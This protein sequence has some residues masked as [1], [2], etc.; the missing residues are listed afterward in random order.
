MNS[1][2]P[3]IGLAAISAFLH[4]APPEAPPA[5][6]PTQAPA[7]EPSSAALDRHRDGSSE[8][9]DAQDE[10]SADVQQL[11]IEQTVP[12]V[13]KLFKEVETIMDEATDHLAAND[14]GGQTLAAQTEVIEKIHAAAKERQKQSGSGQSGSAMM[15]MMERMMGKTPGEGDPQKGKGDKPS[16]Q[17]GGGVQGN[18]DSANTTTG[19]A[20]SN[21]KSEVRRVPKAA[22]TAGQEIPSEFRSAFD[23]FNRGSEVRLKSPTAKP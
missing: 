13:I 10:L 23:A 12:E 22:G 18:S 17:G 4:A 15:D 3:I 2:F 20:D 21:G 7:A 5:T 1:L 9:A 11:T 8:V 6:P 16:D 14:T 19:G